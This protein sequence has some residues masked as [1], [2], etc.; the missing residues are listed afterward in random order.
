MNDEVSEFYENLSKFLKRP[1]E[2][3]LN[4]NLSKNIDMLRTVLSQSK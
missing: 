2:E 4:E 3:V 1:V